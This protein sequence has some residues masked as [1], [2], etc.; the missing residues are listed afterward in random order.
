M[1]AVEDP[2]ASALLQ[3][4]VD[5]LD[6]P[7]ARERHIEA[8]GEAI[9]AIRRRDGRMSLMVVPEAAVL[10][11]SFVAFDADAL[12]RLG[13]VIRQR[14]VGGVSVD[15]DFEPDDVMAFL[16]TLVPRAA[17]D[18]DVVAML[19]PQVVDEMVA[20][21]TAPW[22]GRRRAVDELLASC[23]VIAR[24]EGE[25]RLYLREQD[26]RGPA[27]V[28]VNGRGVEGDAANRI[29]D[30]RGLGSVCLSAPL[31]REEIEALCRLLRSALRGG[32]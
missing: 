23:R 13:S 18:D 31:Q 6:E 16:D 25:L 10:N 15:D 1:V 4:L 30:T 2:L 27:C 12:A 21:A 26:E 17:A 14:D 20:A 3:A 22:L 5:F 19:A 32:D 8:V 11:D 28:F 7:A 29:V 24:V 9:R